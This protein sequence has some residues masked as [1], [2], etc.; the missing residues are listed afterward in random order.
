MIIFSLNYLFCKN[1][2]SSYLNI[3]VPFDSRLIGWYVECIIS[4]YYYY[5]YYLLYSPQIHVHRYR[6][7][8]VL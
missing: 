1:S 2:V 4:C 8:P 3:S 5:Y 7:S 6:V